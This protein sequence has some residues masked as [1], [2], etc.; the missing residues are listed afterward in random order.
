[1]KRT[2]EPSPK[3]KSVQ[4]SSLEPVIGM[5][6]PLKGNAMLEDVDESNSLRNVHNV[7]IAEDDVPGQAVAKHHVGIPS[8][9]FGGA[10]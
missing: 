5:A 9:K 2:M 6:E 1:M 7:D 8:A 4:H 10:R 3:K